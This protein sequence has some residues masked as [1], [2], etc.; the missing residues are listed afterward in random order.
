M[1]VINVIILVAS[2]AITGGMHVDGL[3]DTLDGFIGGCNKEARLKIM[4][5][6]A[7]GAFGVWGI[8]ISILAKY[9]LLNNIPAHVWASSLIC[10]GVLSRFSQ[11]QLG[12][13]SL[14]AGIS[15]DGLGRPFTDYIKR[16]GFLK[17]VIITTIIIGLL[18][19]LKGIL[20]LLIISSITIC[21][22]R[23]SV[24]KIDGITGD[25]LGATS[26]VN[27]VCVLLL[28]TLLF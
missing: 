28:T 10:M 25:V 11:V 18:L 4:K 3:S 12:Y 8:T 20:I 23:I 2:F 5:D 26:E 22:K 15:K 24:N 27:E 6:S 17:A 21:I 9:V 14:Y 1:P 19:G 13:I 16:G 7:A